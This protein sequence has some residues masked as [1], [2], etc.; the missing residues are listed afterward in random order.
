MWKSAKELNIECE[1]ERMWR[2]KGYEAEYF[3]S[4]LKLNN[5]NFIDSRPLDVEIS[6]SFIIIPYIT[7]LTRF[8]VDCYDFMML[9]TR[10]LPSVSC[11]ATANK[12]LTLLLCSGNYIRRWIYSYPSSS[13][14]F[15]PRWIRAPSLFE[16]S[17]A[18][19]CSFAVRAWVENIFHYFA[20]IHTCPAHLNL[21]LFSAMMW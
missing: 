11:L 1:Y 6:T 21:L 3:N 4:G 20:V 13:C 15:D 19:F 12:T 17:S 8:R 16:S 14:H 2:K 5:L 9:K 7:P 10:H 18:F